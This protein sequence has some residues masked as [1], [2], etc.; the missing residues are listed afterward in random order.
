MLPFLVPALFTFYIQGVLKF[1]RKLRRQRVKLKLRC[2]TSSLCKFEVKHLNFRNCIFSSCNLK[3][4]SK[5]LVVNCLMM[6][7]KFRNMLERSLHKEIVVICQVIPQ[8]VEVAQGVPGRLRLQIVL[9][10][11]TTRVVGRQS[12]AAAA[13]TPGEIPGSHFQGLSRPQGTWFHRGEP[14]KKSPVTPP[15]IDPGSCDMYCYEIIVNLL[16]IIEITW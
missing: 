11:G 2:F 15:G 1:K 10:L 6:T 8:Q 3:T 16:V 9:T 7:W 14:R 5:S 4:W 13:F 12:Y